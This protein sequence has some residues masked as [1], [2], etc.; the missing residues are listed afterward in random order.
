M[1]D[2]IAVLCA[3]EVL[4]ATVVKEVDGAGTV[5]GVWLV[6]G[7]DDVEVNGALVAVEAADVGATLL[8][9]RR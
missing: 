6:T 1:V 9:Y 2:A 4:G 3:A 5:V 8:Y 7:G